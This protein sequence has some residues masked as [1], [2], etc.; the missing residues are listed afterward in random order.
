MKT[1]FLIIGAIILTA[2]CGRADKQGE[3]QATAVCVSDPLHKAGSAYL[4]SDERNDPVMCWCETDK[5]GK[6]FFYLSFFDAAAQ[7]FSSA[8]SIPIGQSAGIHEEGMPKVAVKSNGCIVAVYE[9]AGP[10]KENEWAGSVHYLQSFD[11]GKTWTRPQPVHADTTVGGSHSFASMTRLANGEIGVC[12]LDASLDVKKG[13]RPVKFASTNGRAGF[14]NEVLV[15]PR[16]CECCR[17]AVS[18]DAK[19]NV[20]AV[21]RAIGNDGIRDIAISTSPDNGKTFSRAVSFSSD[22]WAIDGCPHNGPCVAN[23]GKTTYATWFTG[24]KNKGVYYGEVSKGNK[25]TVKR[26]VSA[27]G[28]N[29]QL[30]FLPD[31]KKII[32]YSE[33]IRKA[34]SVYSRIVVNKVGGDTVSALVVTP[35]KAHASYPVI[36]SYGANK[37]VIAWSENEK[38][39]YKL[40]D[41]SGI[42]KEVTVPSNP[43]EA[44]T[45]SKGRTGLANNTDPACGM[46]IDNDVQDTALV[47]HKVTGFCSKQCKERFLAARAV[48]KT[49]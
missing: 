10:T 47:N 30:C 16:A 41:A 8:T 9:T 49:E 23:A 6:K 37:I 39:F 1:L 34:D 38:V 19:G 15:E 29:I 35:E 17:T 40:I 43:V 3:P 18:S 21:F 25:T 48:V 27:D 24:G 7:K 13:G 4:T 11:K 42:V 2:S 32:A 46:Q 45:V 20:S 14:Q 26:Q 36:C 33:Q 22:N 28:R 44:K 12:W 31:G 5:A